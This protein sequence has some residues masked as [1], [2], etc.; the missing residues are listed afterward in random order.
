MSIDRRASIVG[1][2]LTIVAIAYP[3]FAFALVWTNYTLTSKKLGPRTNASLVSSPVSHLPHVR[4]LL[5]A[6]LWEGS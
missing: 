5:L 3:F 6:L 2:W 4:V 1:L